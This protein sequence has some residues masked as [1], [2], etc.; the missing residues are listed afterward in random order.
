MQEISIAF[1]FSARGWVL[2]I[3]MVPDAEHP[4]RRW[5]SARLISFPACP[6]LSFW[7]PQR[8]AAVF[9]AG[10][11]GL[12]VYTPKSWRKRTFRLISAGVWPADSN[13]FSKSL[14]R[15]L[16]STSGCLTTTVIVVCPWPISLANQRL[17]TL[18][19]PCAM[20]SYSVSAVTSTVCSTFFRSRH[21]TLQARSA[22]RG[23]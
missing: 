8:S 21:V 2:I 11:L 18:S 13:Q 15:T 17:G 19:K 5:G 22:T 9:T 1:A 7:L 16:C 4:S 23:I 3:I 14:T 12:S 6:A 20:A 10:R